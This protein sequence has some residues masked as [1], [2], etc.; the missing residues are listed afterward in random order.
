MA[1]YFCR[2]ELRGDPSSSEYAKLHAAMTRAGFLNTV[3]DD[4][5]AKYNLPH[6]VYSLSGILTLQDANQAAI[7]AAKSVQSNFLI[8]TTEAVRWTGWL[9]KI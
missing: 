2:V 4:A 8:L 9:N 1:L 6:A 3:V 5:G 7:A